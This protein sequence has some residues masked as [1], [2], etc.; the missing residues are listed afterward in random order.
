MNFDDLV[1]V[2]IIV[3]VIFLVY[4]NKNSDLTKISNSEVWNWVDYKGN[5]RSFVITR[6][7]K[8]G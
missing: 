6:D 7:V 1:I 8:A 3:V 5:E 2:A 4:K